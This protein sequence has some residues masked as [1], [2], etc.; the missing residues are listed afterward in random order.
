MVL[1]VVGDAVANLHRHVIAFIIGSDVF[2]GDNTCTERAAKW[3]GTISGE[4]LEGI[5]CVT[6]NVISKTLGGD[7][8]VVN[9]V[10]GVTGA[11]TRGGGGNRGRRLCGID[12]QGIDHLSRQRTLRT[13][14]SSVAR[15]SIADGDVD[16]R[17]II[18]FLLC[19]DI[20][21]RI[22]THRD[23][24]AALHLMEP[25]KGGS[26]CRP[27]IGRSIRYRVR[28]GEGRLRLAL[29]GG[30]L[31]RPRRNVRG[32]EHQITA[33]TDLDIGGTIGKED[34]RIL[35][36]DGRRTNGIARVRAIGQTDPSELTLRGK[37]DI[38]AV[39]R[40]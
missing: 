32:K 5:V 25:L 22:H 24:R 11:T 27:G 9:L 40:E 3:C 10:V 4:F 13:A 15:E 16:D 28:S 21:K 14:A 18:E 23:E 1:I 8:K 34:V 31:N 12:H 30:K 39:K 2:D 36:R 6:F 19:A 33:G 29:R 7:D 20:D 35:C 17:T 26:D 38:A 37:C